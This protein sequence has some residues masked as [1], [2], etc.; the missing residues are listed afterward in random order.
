MQTVLN[1]RH[2]RP[3][4]GSTLSLEKIVLQEADLGANWLSKI[5]SDNTSQEILPHTYLFCATV[6]KLVTLLP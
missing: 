3:I 4:L 1:K 2:V 6:I 5:C